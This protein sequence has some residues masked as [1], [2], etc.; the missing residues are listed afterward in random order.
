MTQSQGRARGPAWECPLLEREEVEAAIFAAGIELRL[1]TEWSHEVPV[2]A[3]AR[4]LTFVAET[5]RRRRLTKRQYSAFATAYERFEAQL[6][7]LRTSDDPPPDLPRRESGATEWKDWLVEAFV[8][9][10]FNEND[11]PNRGGR[12]RGASWAATRRLLAYFQVAFDTP[13]TATSGG[14]AARFLNECFA[15]VRKAVLRSSNPE[16]PTLR[17]QLLR[18]FPPSEATLKRWLRSLRTGA[19]E[20]GQPVLRL[21]N[22]SQVRRYFEEYAK[23]WQGY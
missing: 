9:D 20:L 23:K 2:F 1:D 11:Q 21:S 18:L 4:I 8:D 22:E 17:G 3:L 5:S 6:R 12:P 16:D 14:P 13:P 10:I 7:R 19:D 15:Q